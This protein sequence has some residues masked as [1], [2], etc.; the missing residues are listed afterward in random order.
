MV[1]RHPFGGHRMSGA[2]TKAGGRGYL[3]SFMFSRVVAENTLR[4]GFAAE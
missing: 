3:E 4:R 1:E 2:G